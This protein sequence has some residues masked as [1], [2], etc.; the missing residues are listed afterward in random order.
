MAG[1]NW[2]DKS[3]TINIRITF[4]GTGTSQGVPIIGCDCEV[5]LSADPRDKRLRPSVLVE[6]GGKHIVIDAGPDFRYQ[7]LRAGVQKVDAILLTHEHNDH[8]IGLDDVRPFNFKYWRNMPVYGT[9]RVLREVRQRF[10]YIFSADKYPGAPMIDLHEINKEKDFEVEGI[11]VT[12]IE[13]MH[14][15]MPVLGFRFGDFTYITDAKTISEEEKQK[16]KNSKVLVL[17]ALHHSPHHAHLNLNQ[18]LEWVE[19]L[20]PER[21]FF[22]HMSHHMGLH[23]AINARLPKG[24]ALAHDGLVVEI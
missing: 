21:A 17:N 24:V 9:A 12:P 6:A 14:G 2:K 23:D 5:C 19:E 16:V 4:L 7:M 20:K 8:V 22:I 15:K 10:A 11:R 18:A 13:V 3:T 1:R